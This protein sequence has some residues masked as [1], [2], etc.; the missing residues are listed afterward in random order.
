[1][2]KENLEDKIIHKKCDVCGQ[3]IL[4]DKLGFGSCANC[5][6]QNSDAA[7]ER[8]DYPYLDNFVSLNNAK[9]L[10][11]EG[12]P[13]KPS[14]DEFIEFIRVYGEVQFKYRNN[15]YGIIRGDKISM[16]CVGVNYSTKVYL[17]YEDF[18]NRADI[19]GLLLKDIWDLVEAV[20]YLQ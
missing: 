7:L 6:W 17:S 2:D 9:Q 10:Y 1:M 18:K 19:G 12:K 14:F 11:S 16:F 5:G 20:D 13:I 3:Y 15:V 8:P 4:I